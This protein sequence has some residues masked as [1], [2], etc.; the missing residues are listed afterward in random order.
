MLEKVSSLAKNPSKGKRLNSIQTNSERKQTHSR[1][2]TTEASPKSES[3]DNISKTHLRTE[4]YPLPESNK[5][6]VNQNEY[7]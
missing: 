6:I 5:I 3:K 1:S 4:I 2:I 7:I